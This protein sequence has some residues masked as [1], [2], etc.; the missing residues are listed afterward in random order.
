M[1]GASVNAVWL[2]SWDTGGILG[3]PEY[4][5]DRGRYPGD[6]VS[7]DTRRCSQDTVSVSRD[8]ED[9]AVSW[10]YHILR[11]PLASR[12]YRGMNPQRL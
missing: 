2:A 11:I 4:P 10:G 8:G 9:T 6:T 3:T 12:G 7:Q 1:G 5:Q